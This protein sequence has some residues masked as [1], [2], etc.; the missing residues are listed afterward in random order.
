MIK[1]QL[2]SGGQLVHPHSPVDLNNQYRTNP[3]NCLFYVSERCKHRA[4]V[5][6]HLRCDVSVPGKCG[7]RLKT[8]NH[9]GGKL[10]ATW[11]FGRRFSTRPES[12]EPRTDDW[13]V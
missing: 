7:L 5:R 8:M 1:R 3:H 6:E 12:T 10:L 11:R 2:L 13:L 4:K 9:N